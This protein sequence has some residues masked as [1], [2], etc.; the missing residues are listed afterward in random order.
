MSSTFE[1]RAVSVV[2]RSYPVVLWRQP[3]SGWRLYCRFHNTLGT[4]TGHTIAKVLQWAQATA[5]EFA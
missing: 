5:Q 1:S 3:G 2:K 4:F